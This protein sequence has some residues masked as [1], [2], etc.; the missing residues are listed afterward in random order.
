M[1]KKN[2]KELKCN[3]T[4]HLIPEGEYLA[5]CI[6]FEISYYLGKERKVYLYFRIHGGEFDGVELFMACNYPE[7]TKSFGL[8]INTQ[9]QVAMGRRRK[10]GEKIALKDFKNRMFN[11]KVRDVKR[12]YSDG[13]PMPAFLSYTIVDRI[14]SPETGGVC[15]AT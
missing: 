1:S 3:D 2:K 10:K 9:W 5:Q 13:T 11:V 15:S 4:P 7:G 8:K 14:V 12:K 6:R